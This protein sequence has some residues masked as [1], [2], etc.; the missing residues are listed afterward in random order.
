MRY[1]ESI[2]EFCVNPKVDW[3]GKK[4]LVM[5]ELGESIDIYFT[6]FNTETEKFSFYSR[7]HSEF[8]GI[9]AFC[10]ILEE[11]GH[12]V[13][14]LPFQNLGKTPSG[15]RKLVL[16]WKFVHKSSVTK[17]DW[18]KEVDFTISGVSEG[19][20]F[21]TFTKEQTKIILKNK[22]LLLSSFLIKTLDEASRHSLVGS[23]T[24]RGWIL[25]INMRGGP[26]K[27]RYYGNVACS[28]MLH[29][30][31]QTSDF[32]IQEE[33]LEYLK[34]K[35]HWGSWIYT[36]LPKYIGTTLL[37]IFANK[38]GNKG[39]GYLAH[40]G[41]MPTK[42]MTLNEKSHNQA[43]VWTTISIPS[44]VVPVAAGSM[45]WQERL[46]LSL[47]LHPSL[48]KDLKETNFI[49][50]K[51]IDHIMSECKDLQIGPK[52]HSITEEDLQ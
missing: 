20:C 40:F 10:D 8:D 37:R 50:K 51:W 19:F 15:W 7:P 52:I 34:E 22:K 36:N 4:Y 41:T 33:L 39:Y 42:K 2:I 43:D 3:S 47:R 27:E 21:A 6:K 45:I 29:V 25:P 13:E 32:E 16:M 38:L 9:G 49:M 44:R 28:V 26:V 46:S 18:N 35:L 48:K 17:A 12:V 30:G 1:N 24:K 23:K 31:N 14:K 5:K 11:Q